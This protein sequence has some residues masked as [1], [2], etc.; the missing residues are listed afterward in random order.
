MFFRKSS[1]RR[2]LQIFFEGEHPR[3]IGECEIALDMPGPIF[4]RVRDL[5]GIVF[6]QPDSQIVGEPV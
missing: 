2:R 5:A 4:R 6:R 3:I 1:A